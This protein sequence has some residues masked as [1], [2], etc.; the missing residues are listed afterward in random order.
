MFHNNV[1]VVFVMI[2]GLC[3]I[4]ESGVVPSKQLLQSDVTEVRDRTSELDCSQFIDDFDVLRQF[5][6]P[7]VIN[8]PEDSD[9]EKSTARVN[10]SETFVRSISIRY[11]THIPS[12]IYC[13]SNLHKLLVQTTP[14]ENSNILCD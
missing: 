6:F 3:T 11:E 14:F 5:P 8:P 7:V 9:Y 13:L 10:E 4:G 2:Y 1:L 12:S